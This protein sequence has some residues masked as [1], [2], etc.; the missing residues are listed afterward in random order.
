TLA[1]ACIEADHETVRLTREIGRRGPPTLPLPPGEAVVWDGRYEIVAD[2][3]GLT[4]YPLAGLA[5]RLPADQRTALAQIPAIAR[6]ALPAIVDA[7]HGTVSCPILAEGAGVRVAS[8][9]LAR[10]R[11][12]C[13]LVTRENE[14]GDPARGEMKRGVL[15]WT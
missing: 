6:P 2:R 11:A 5:V 1:G 8:L 12:A 9:V 10:L 4:V 13:G 7:A 3:P 14:G 15:S